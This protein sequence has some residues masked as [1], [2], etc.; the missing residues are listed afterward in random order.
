[1]GS[2]TQLNRR[3]REVEPRAIQCERADVEA[4]KVGQESSVRDGIVPLGN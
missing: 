4:L 2:A 3:A 1:M